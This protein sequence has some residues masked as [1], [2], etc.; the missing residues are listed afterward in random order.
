[1]WRMKRALASQDLLC[2]ATEER[3]GSFS[4]GFDV[5]VWIS[6][7]LQNSRAEL[8]LAYL[9]SSYYYSE[10]GADT[11]SFL[12]QLTIHRHKLHGAESRQQNIFSRIYRLP[13]SQDVLLFFSQVPCSPIR[14]PEL[15]SEMGNTDI[16]I[17]QLRKLDR[18]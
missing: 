5:R 1:M 9:C 6:G 11:I 3:S 7:L 10:P 2:G 8:L 13:G 18:E 17:L 14:P 16:F 15:L 12:T 4:Q